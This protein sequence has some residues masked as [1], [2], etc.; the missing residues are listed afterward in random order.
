VVSTAPA[1][2]YPADVVAAEAKASI[3][4]DKWLQTGRELAQ[5]ESDRQRTDTAR[6]FTIG[7]WLIA[8]EQH[9]QKKAYKEAQSVF[10]DH[11]R[12][13]LRNLAYVAKQFPASLRNDNLSW[14]HHYVVA[15]L[16][17][18][19]QKQWLNSAAANTWSSKQLRRELR[20]L[21]ERRVG[22]Q[23]P[24]TKT[25]ELTVALSPRQIT[26]LRK[27]VKLFKKYHESITKEDLARALLLKVLSDYDYI[28][29]PDRR[30]M[31]V[32]ERFSFVSSEVWRE[33]MD[34]FDREQ[35]SEPTVPKATELAESDCSEARSTEQRM[36]ACREQN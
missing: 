4:L 20:A 3:A 10:K 12:A 16:G 17:P 2:E 21:C 5:A 35:S 31:S 26:G 6:Q 24:Q 18:E 33:T 23:Q 15:K 28:P 14:N 13:T 8:G 11:T 22:T 29:E 30:S 7:D 19:Q 32:A 36:E 27:A 25:V 34:E 1:F 9:W